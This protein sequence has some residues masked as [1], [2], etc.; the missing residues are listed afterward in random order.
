[1]AD[2]H[3][4]GAYGSLDALGAGCCA[5]SPLCCFSLRQVGGMGLLFAQDKPVSVQ[6]AAVFLASNKAQQV[7]DVSICCVPLFL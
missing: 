6:R 2:G 3:G 7:T 1:M 5:L 4:D